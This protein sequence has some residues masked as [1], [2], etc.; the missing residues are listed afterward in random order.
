MTATP[1]TMATPAEEDRFTSVEELQRKG[2]QLRDPWAGLLAVIPG[3]PT[4]LLLASR[5]Q[6][7]IGEWEDADVRLV[8]VVRLR[9]ARTLPQEAEPPDVIAEVMGLRRRVLKSAVKGPPARPGAIGLRILVP[10]IDSG[11]A[12][13]R[14]IRR[15]VGHGEVWPITLADMADN[16][17]FDD[18]GNRRMPLATAM[19]LLEHELAVGRVKL[20]P[21]A[22]GL[23]RLHHTLRR[24]PRVPH[25][26]VAGVG[27][28]V[29]LAVWAGFRMLG[30][31]AK[32][33]KSV[34]LW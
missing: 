26:E 24:L 2:F 1:S 28:G 3:P 10:A 6:W 9:I 34:R 12:L 18:D 7:R 31:L 19:G 13:A 11:H 27:L 25:A 29:L 22:E 17:P 16:S 4:I 8:T 30:Q 15:H 5:E 32:P 33:R 23:E 14:E 20:H 21:A